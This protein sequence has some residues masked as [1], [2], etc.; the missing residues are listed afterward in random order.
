VEK[1]LS[2]IKE[3]GLYDKVTKIRCMLLV[4]KLN[5]TLLKDPKIEIIGFSQDYS[6]YEQATINKLFEDSIKEDFNVLYIHSKGIRHN[7]T[8]P[9]VTDWVKYLTYFNIYKHDQCMKMLNIY[10]AV[11]VNLI[12]DPVLH[13]SGNF[14]W[15]KAEHLRKLGPCPYTNYNS[16]EFWVTS[17]KGNY[18]GLWNSLVNHY[19]SR[20]EESRYRDN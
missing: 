13:F 2:D 8:N 1:L 6:L 3:S 19:I 7:G 15:S 20:Y 11:G 17:V 16:P 5:L 12:N 9:C 18:I 14:W 4:N 10:D